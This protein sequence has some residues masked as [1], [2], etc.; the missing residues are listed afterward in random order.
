MNLYLSTFQVLGSK[1]HTVLI[2]HT[3]GEKASQVFIDWLLAEGYPA[4]I[5]EVETTLLS[6]GPI[7]I[8]SHL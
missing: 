4:D 8:I 3:S 7:G 5:V 1:I 2:R 6:D